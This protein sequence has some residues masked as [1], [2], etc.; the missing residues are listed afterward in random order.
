M[1]ARIAQ[2]R[3]ERSKP[4]QAQQIAGIKAG[5]EA[6]RQSVRRE[7]AQSNR[8]LEA[9]KDIEIESENDLEP[10]TGR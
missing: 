4:L 3:L 8:E 7:R 1:A 10:D 2:R 6:L 9:E 5:R